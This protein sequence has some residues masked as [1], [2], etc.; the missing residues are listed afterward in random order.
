MN[1]LIILISL[2]PAAAGIAAEPPA[3]PSVHYDFESADG[4]TL[5]DIAGTVISAGRVHS[6]AAHRR[7]RAGRTEVAPPALMRGRDGQALAFGGPDA[8]GFLEV[9]LAPALRLEDDDFTIAFWYKAN[10]LG[11][12]FCG[13]TTSAPFW[14]Y[15]WSRDRQGQWRLRF[16]IGTGEQ[17]G[18][19][20]SQPLDHLDDQQWHLY[21]LFVDRGRTARMYVDRQLVAEGE[22]RG[23]RGPL[24]HVLT[25]GGPYDYLDGLM[26]DFMLFRG[27]YD[28]ALVDTLFLNNPTAA[29]SSP[30]AGSERVQANN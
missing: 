11:G 27:A 12:L 24:K 6:P 26:D 28:G 17:S 5:A 18:A 2:L 3:A 9:S 30:D 23:A 14:Q 22:I 15:G 29:V 7:L 16:W 21:V 4:A 25:I 10:K 13:G 8:A 19:V 20:F 1:L